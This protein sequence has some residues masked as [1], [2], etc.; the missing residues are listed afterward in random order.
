MDHFL[1]LSD[2]S[3]FLSST[4]YVVLLVSSLIVFDALS[5][6]S[7]FHHCCSPLFHPCFSP[8]EVHLYFLTSLLQEVW[9]FPQVAKCFFC[10]EYDIVTQ[11]GFEGSASPHC[12]CPNISLTN[13]SCFSMSIYCLLNGGKVCFPSLLVNARYQKK[14]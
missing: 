3:V 13:V 9:Y 2:D 6:L 5:K 14:I 12:C 11:F 1:N 4:L 10:R 7:L 8:C